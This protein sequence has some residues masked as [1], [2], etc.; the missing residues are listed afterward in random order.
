MS[1]KNKQEFSGNRDE[2]I[3]MGYAPC[4]RCNP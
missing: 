1:E 4:K 3:S 2:V